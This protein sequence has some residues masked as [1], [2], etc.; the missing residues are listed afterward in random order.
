[1]AT[2][3]PAISPFSP[4]SISFLGSSTDGTSVVVLSVVCVL[5]LVLIIAYIIWRIRRTNLK[6]V[7]LLRDPIRLKGAGLPLVV[8]GT[9]IPNTMNGQEYSYSFW[10]YLVQFDAASDMIPLFGRGTSNSPAVYLDAASNKMYVSIAKNSAKVSAIPTKLRDI[11]TSNDY[12]TA[13]IDYVPLQRWVNVAVVVQDF[14][15]TLY[16]DGDIYTV[17]NVVG[18]QATSVGTRR[19][20]FG[21]TN[22]DVYIGCAATALQATAFMSQLQFY[23]YALMQ[24]DVQ[25]RYAAGPLTSSTLGIL[26]IPA[27]GV[28]SPVYKITD[29]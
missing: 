8:N 24:L 6:S 20:V 15:M 28:R 27:Y 7:V 5:L 18:S 13:T 12:V 2:P 11:Y 3:A 22:G 16:L 19:N 17:A 14:M 26:G 25:R 1:M 10:L 4:A 9:K 21:A 29:S 23:N